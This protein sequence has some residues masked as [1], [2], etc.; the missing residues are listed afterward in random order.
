VRT[1]SVFPQRGGGGVAL[2]L[3]KKRLHGAFATYKDCKYQLILRARTVTTLFLRCVLVVV[4][5]ARAPCL[6]TRRPGKTTMRPA[7]PRRHCTAAPE[8]FGRFPRPTRLSLI[9]T[10]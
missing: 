9:T 1:V 3:G 2:R 7:V 6:S 4:V 8:P 5:V 10:Q